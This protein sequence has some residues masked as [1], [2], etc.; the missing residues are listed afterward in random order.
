MTDKLGD[1]IEPGMSTPNTKNTTRRES[2]TA[3]F[4][5]GILEP[6]YWHGLTVMTRQEAYYISVHEKELVL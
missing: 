3:A 1:T 5:T 2:A 6:K 4:S